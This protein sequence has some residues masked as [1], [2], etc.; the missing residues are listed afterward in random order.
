MAVVIFVCPQSGAQVA[1]KGVV[2]HREEEVV[3]I[4]IVAIVT[5]CEHYWANIVI[6]VIVTLQYGQKCKEVL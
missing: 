3:N 5:Y 6:V 2:E 1:S 4:A